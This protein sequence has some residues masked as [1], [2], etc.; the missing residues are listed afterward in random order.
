MILVS[1][2][3]DFMPVNNA[4]ENTIEYAGSVPS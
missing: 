3:L 2:K 4:A 1:P